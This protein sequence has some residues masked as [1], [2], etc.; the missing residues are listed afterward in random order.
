MKKTEKI[1][2]VLIVTAVGGF[3]ALVNGTYGVMG[4]HVAFDEHL[5]WSTAGFVYWTLLLIAIICFAAVITT[6][7]LLFR[8]KGSN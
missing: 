4:L 3:F 5:A 2:V 8:A 6:W 1:V 7:L